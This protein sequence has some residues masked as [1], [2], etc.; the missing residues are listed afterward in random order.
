M[1]NLAGRS[2]G[3]TVVQDSETPPRPV[4]AETR[5]AQDQTLK[6]AGLLVVADVSERSP[7]SENL[8][9]RSQRVKS[10]TE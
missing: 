7:D 6:P 10:V 5:L 2:I 1:S 4:D 8:E 3:G 9:S